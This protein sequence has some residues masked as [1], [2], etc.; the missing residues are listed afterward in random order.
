MIRSPVP[1][2]PLQ[3]A[4][5]WTCWLAGGLLRLVYVL[6]LHPPTQ[7]VYSDM[8]GYA[9]RALNRV[10]G[11]PETIGDSLYP[12][13]AS[14]LFATLH[15]L[16][17]SSML[18]VIAQWLLSLATMAG[19]WVIARMLYGNRVAV[20]ALAATSLYLPLFHY[21]GL[22]LAENPF[23]ACLVWAYACLIRA[24]AAPRPAGTALWAL[25]AGLLAGLAAALKATILL[26]V[27]LTGLLVLGW[28]IRHRRRGALTLACGV[29]L[30]MSSLLLPLAERCT[31]LADGHFCLVSTNTGMNALMGH[32]GAYREFVWADPGR[33]LYY[34]FTSPSAALRG[35]SEPLRLG[36]GVYDVPANVEELRR[37]VA[38]DPVGA[39]RYSLRNVVDLFVGFDSWPA[40]VY[41]Q[42]L[43][44]RAYQLL[45]LW[46][47]L[48][49]AACWLLYR[50]P[51]LIRLREDSLAEWLL[52]A[53]LLGLM[54]TAFISLGE[55]RFRI[56]FDGFVLI[57]A[58]QALLALVSREQRQINLGSAA[59]P[60]IAPVRSA[61]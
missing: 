13:G 26:P 56:P 15:R 24:L 30:G 9:L 4:I 19:V 50:L 32:A 16:D 59:L 29:L 61:G 58:A 60:V 31:R 20:L 55:L 46:L 38:A 47:L 35:Y 37:R 11:I 57:L 27:A 51:R 6:V 36:F 54:A 8:Q 42:Q 33:N 3:R 48:P 25:A 14:L 7:H 2:G 40:A 53:P 21:A 23:T 28:L 49:L 39:L 17:P 41:R 22:F 44:S 1:L 18:T 5:V 34:S 10:Q 43:W 12:P 45:Y 52:L